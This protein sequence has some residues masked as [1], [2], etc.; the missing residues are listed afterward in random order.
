MPEVEIDSTFKKRLARKEP[1]DQAAILE[2]IERL[3]DNP[4]H[5][6]LKTH[7]IQGHAGVFSARVDRSNRVTFNWA[8]GVIVLRNHCNHEAVYSRP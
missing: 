5:P 3:S 7:A 1:K 8:D 4:R 2:C 6:G